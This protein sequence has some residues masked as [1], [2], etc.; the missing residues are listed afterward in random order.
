M[1]K[2]KLDLKQKLEQEIKECNELQ[3]IH[4]NL[5]KKINSINIDEKNI[6]KSNENSILEIMK[7]VKE[8]ILKIK[9][10]KLYLEAIIFLFVLSIIIGFILTK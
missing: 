4:K 9:N 10:N 2:N 1:N 5:Y 6:I 7:D 3:S 8:L